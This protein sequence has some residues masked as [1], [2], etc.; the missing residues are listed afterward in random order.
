M[1]IDYIYA[2]LQWSLLKIKD[3]MLRAN[4][5]LLIPLFTKPFLK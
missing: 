1:Y 5:G 3:E 4:E 2:E